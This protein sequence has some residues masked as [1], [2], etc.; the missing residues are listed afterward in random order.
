MFFASEICLKY[1]PISFMLIVNLT[2]IVIGD[3]ICYLLER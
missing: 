1:F 3:A 2:K